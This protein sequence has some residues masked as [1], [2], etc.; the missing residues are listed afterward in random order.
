[1]NVASVTV[2]AIN[3]GFTP[4][5]GN[6]SASPIR[7]GLA[8]IV[9]SVPCPNR[10]IKR[11]NGRKCYSRDSSLT[12]AEQL[13]VPNDPAS[14]RISISF[15]HSDQIVLGMIFDPC[16]IAF[17][18][19]V[20]LPDRGIG[21]DQGNERGELTREVGVRLFERNHQESPEPTEPGIYSGASCRKSCVS[22]LRCFLRARLLS[23]WPCLAR[24]TIGCA[25]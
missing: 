19:R 7:F 9:R 17:L 25:C 20:P 15:R 5:V 2:I 24:T 4:F 13:V 11:P 6:S 8:V 16:P 23:P 22:W 1:M 14:I 12:G 21:Q 3:Q 10:Y 18:Q